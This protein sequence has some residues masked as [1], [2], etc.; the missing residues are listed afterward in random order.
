MTTTSLRSLMM[1]RRRWL[2]LG[3]SSALSLGLGG[4]GSL[5]LPREARSADYKALVCIF[6][7]GGNDGQN[8][9][10]PTDAT[11][12]P[13]YAAV[14]Q[15]LALPQ[16]SLVPMGGTQH[17]LHPAMA[18]LAGSCGAG[19]LVPVLN[20]GPLAQPLTKAQYRAAAPNSDQV[21]ESLFSHSDQQT[22][23][24][25]ATADAQARSGWGGRAAATLGTANPVISV[26]GNSRFGQSDAQSPIVLPKAGGYFGVSELAPDAWRQQSAAA[27][28]R[29]D[30]LRKLQQMPQDG[31]LGDAYAQ[32]QT[33][34]F[35]LSDRLA[36]L[37]AAK[38]GSAGGFPEIDAAFASLTANGVLLT[39]LADQLYQIAKLVAGR[40][41]VQGSRQIFFA[42]LGGF[43]THGGQVGSNP[44]TGQHADLL[45]TLANA[46]AA[47]D[48]AMTR[49]GMAS[50]VTT[51]TESDFGR[52][53]KPNNSSGTDH[54]WGN[55]Q[56]VMGGAVQ[57]GKAYGQAPALVLGGDDDVGV[58]SWE[59]QGRWIPTT[60]VDQY[61]ATLLAWF[62]ASSSQLDTILPNLARFGTARTLG[63][64]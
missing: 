4:V 10:V 43:D 6:L 57:G 44:A 2:D 53:F 55:H 64:V 19:R 54:A 62:G 47:F 11:R 36:S 28:A 27:S 52:T 49:L 41:S 37:V 35:A 15:G 56:L 21:P 59:L 22:L 25:S 48:N 26:A 51:F 63:F 32:S 45:A 23:W 61:A 38:P 9:V 17:G 34:A 3:A 60:S 58:N 31:D 13:Q 29:A 20:V 8:M 50:S 40:A 30:V 42:S 33:G 16:A 5:L 7:Y 24:E 14:R 46:M 12:Y 1:N 39:P 18:A